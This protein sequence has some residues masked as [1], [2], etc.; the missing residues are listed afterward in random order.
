MLEGDDFLPLDRLTIGDIKAF[1]PGSFVV[2]LT[3]GDPPSFIVADAD[4]QIRRVRRFGD[5]YS[6]S[7][8][9]ET[10][11]GIGLQDFRIEVTRTHMRGFVEY[12]DLRLGALAMVGDD[13]RLLATAANG[14]VQ[15]LPFPIK[16]GG[17][18]TR[19][20]RKSRSANGELLPPLAT[21]T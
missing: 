2:P 3:D 10:A 12:T 9:P 16:L 6:F 18:K 21:K 15:P 4:G 17:V 5:T 13:V 1:P 19:E 8:P 7:D 14:V 11:L 20:M